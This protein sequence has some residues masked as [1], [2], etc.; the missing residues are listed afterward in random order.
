[1]VP[2]VKRALT[3]LDRLALQREPMSLARLSADLALPK[4]SVHGLC[5]TLMNFGYLRR[6]LDGGFSIG[7]AVMR[8][9]EAFAASTDVTREFN[10]LWVHAGAAPD[11]TVVLS[12]LNGT[13]ALY[14][15]VRNSARPLGLAFTVGMRLPAYLSGSGKAMLAMRDPQ[16]VKAL[17]AHG[18]QAR[19]TPKGPGSLKEL[20]NEL[21]LTRQRGYSVDEESVREGV[22]AFGA[23]VF[24]AS[25]QAVAAISVCFN[26]AMLGADQGERHRDVALRV[27]RTLSQ[28]LG[29]EVPA[30]P[31]A[32]TSHPGQA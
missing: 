12:V 4:S 18:L 5:N 28:R 2:A 32:P 23:P 3:L 24:D 19:L 26:K 7:P 14:V 22:Y 25:G 8:L 11:E 17:F 13:D 16:E 1:M 27:A 20:L 31:P 10:A 9:A 21:A 15:A 29:G 6:E 30:T